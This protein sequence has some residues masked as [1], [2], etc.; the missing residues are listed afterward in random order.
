MILF[1]SILL[2]LISHTYSQTTA[3]LRHMS[4]LLFKHKKIHS[5]FFGA[6]ITALVVVTFFF[7]R[8]SP[9]PSPLPQDPLYTDTS[10]SV[11]ER[12]EN[13]LAYMTLNE[14]IGQMA[15]VEKNSIRK[16]EDVSQYGLGGI[17]SGFGGKPEDNTPLGWKQMVENF[18]GESRMSRLEIPIL[19]GVDAIHGHSNVPGA[20][21]FPHFI[22]LGASGDAKLVTAVAHATA[23]EL[24]ATG[25]NWSYSPTYDMPE[26]IRWGRTYETFSDDSDRVSK[27]GVAYIEGLQ[28]NEMQPKHISV[29][30]TPKHYIGVGSMLW[31]TS[32]NEHFKIDQGITPG[33]EEK[34]RTTYLP[35]FAKAVDAGALSIMVGLNSW[36]STK[37]AA[38]SYL[39][40]DVLK[41]E[42]SFQGFVVSDWYG[43][44]EIPGGNYQAA[45]TAINAGVDMVMLPF[46]YRGF[47]KD[48]RRAVQR[49]DIE[50]ERI[51]DAVRRILTAKF[52]L[53]LFD[54]D[55]EVPDISILGS[56]EHR[57]LARKAVAESLVLLKNKNDVLPIRKNATVRVAGSVAD[58][59]GKQA[60]AW[61]VE[62]QGID[63]NWL[64]GATSIL[65]GIKELAGEGA[66]VEFEEHAQFATDSP[67]ADIGI[68]V[69][70][71]SPYAEGWGDTA[72][73]SLSDEDLTTIKNLQKVSQAV[74]VVLVTG[75]PLIITDEIKDW[76]AVVVA[77]LPGSEG[78]GVADVLFG[79]KQFTGSLP[80]PWPAHIA[81]LPISTSGET[82]DGSI[83]LFPRY[84][85]L[86]N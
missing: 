1:Q 74:I 83:V 84:F 53:G 57:T 64:T 54:G 34:L 78:E 21:V 73:P 22:G 58:N 7:L 62:W 68:A 61:T 13:L 8:Q 27:L 19:Y 82:H 30:A 40:T 41:G 71:E 49:G 2:F 29:L 65:S 77:W 26:D 37:L 63:G 28:K 14:K 70:G 39:I 47:I 36:D 31:N 59:I 76:D 4:M 38:D 5:V 80:L 12:V 85:G 67:K 50:E 69:V 35:P 51:D 6:L 56:G 44:Y 10:L 3:I 42:L 33:S 25:V 52:S 16:I 23:D 18:T 11:S 75:R 60:G 15:L 9:P 66:Q 86:E 48:V 81:Q 46:D 45:V 17:L 55:H 32:S 20:T 24:R 43:V 79:K 72:T